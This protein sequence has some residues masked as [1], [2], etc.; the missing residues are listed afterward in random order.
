MIRNLFC[1]LLIHSLNGVAIWFLAGWSFDFFQNQ[2]E[3]FTG[4]LYLLSILGLVIYFALGSKIL[5]NLSPKK[6]ITSLSLVSMIGIILWIFCYYFSDGGLAWFIY[7]VYNAPIYPI[8]IT[9]ELEPENTPLFALIPSF[10]LWAALVLKQT[11]QKR[12]TI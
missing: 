8:L 7:L 12:R 4:S 6:N 5:H 3:A 1:S 11:K 2:N 9:L 10:L